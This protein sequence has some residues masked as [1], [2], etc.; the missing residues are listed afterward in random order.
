MTRKG[1]GKRARSTAA[2]RWGWSG[3]AE[4]RPPVWLKDRLRPA[5]PLLPQRRSGVDSIVSELLDFAAHYHANLHQDEF[6]PTRAERTAALRTLLHDLD[7][8]IF[9]LE[10]LPGDLRSKLSQDLAQEIEKPS[11]GLIDTWGP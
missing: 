6:G 1:R 11:L 7:A 5:I 2:P 10:H 8:V 4:L 3:V 9:H